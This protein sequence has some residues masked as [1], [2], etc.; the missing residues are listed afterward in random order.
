MTSNA[1]S[2]E[3]VEEACTLCGAVPLTVVGTVPGYLEGRSYTVLECDGCGSQ[4]VPA[5][6]VVPDG[7]YDAIYRNAERL[8]GYARYVGTTLSKLPDN[9]SL[10][11]YRVIN[12]QGKISFPAGSDTYERQIKR[13]ENEGVVVK[14]GKISMKIYRWKP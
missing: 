6:T 10:P 3:V 7:L 11:W 9:S 2:G 13:L 8:P 1:R 14:E 5:D 12:S 4:A